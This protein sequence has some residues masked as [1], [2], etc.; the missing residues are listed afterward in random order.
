MKKFV[1]ILLAVISVLSCILM[2]TGCSQPSTVTEILLLN[3]DGGVGS[4]WLEADVAAFTEMVLKNIY[5]NK[6]LKSTW[7]RKNNYK[8]FNI[9]YEN[10]IN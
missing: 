9:N 2:T 3:F 10:N 4:E 5:P 7:Q 8:G 6:P 1:S